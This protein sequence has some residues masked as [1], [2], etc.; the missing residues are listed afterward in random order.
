MSWRSKYASSYNV[1]SNWASI[2][3]VIYHDYAH[4]LYWTPAHRRFLISPGVV[5]SACVCP[6]CP[7]IRR[8]SQT[9]W[10]RAASIHIARSI[11]VEYYRQKHG[12]RVVMTHHVDHVCDM[13]MTTHGSAKRIAEDVAGRAAC[14]RASVCLAECICSASGSA[15]DEFSYY[16]STR[17]APQ[18]DVE[19]PVSVKRR[20]A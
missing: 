2:Y 5:D 13:L 20:Q 18:A 8:A 10:G 19:E 3:P 14:V 6:A 16:C 15:R 4:R 7:I 12:Q 1:Y 11:I 9:P 17:S